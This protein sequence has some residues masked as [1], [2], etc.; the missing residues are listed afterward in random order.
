MD[1]PEA[2]FVFSV[3]FKIETSFPCKKLRRGNRFSGKIPETKAEPL[4]HLRRVLI[5][6]LIV[7]SLLF[8]C[9][10]VFVFHGRFK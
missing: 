6:C 4:C 3:A 8:A 2:L 7:V 9:K 10:G 1:I 5:T